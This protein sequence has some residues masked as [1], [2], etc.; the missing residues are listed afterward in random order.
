MLLLV[1]LAD[2]PGRD[3]AADEAGQQEHREKIRQ[4]LDELHWDLEATDPYA[5]QADRDGVEQAEH[6]AS[7]EGREWPPLAEDH[8]REGDEA[9][10]CRH[11]PGE[12]GILGDR[13]VT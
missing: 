13:D 5:L 4:S 3:R 12:A 11:V 10:A 2:R 7:A 9:L 8:R 1:G 6:Q